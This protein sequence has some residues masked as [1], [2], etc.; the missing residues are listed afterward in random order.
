MSIASGRIILRQHVLGAGWWWLLVA[1]QLG[2]AAADFY[3]APTGNDGNPGTLS[4]PFRAVQQAASILQPGDTAWLRGGT[5]RET[6]RYNSGAGK[7]TVYKPGF[8]FRDVKS[9][10]RWDGK[11]R[12]RN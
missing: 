7:S 11:G 9:V 1:G 5:Y 8:I 6:V 4:Q 12:K 3:V 2:A 10:T